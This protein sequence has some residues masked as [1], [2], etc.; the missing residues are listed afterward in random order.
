MADMAAGAHVELV[1][2]PRADDV[3]IGAAR[4]MDAGA[5]ALAI[6]ALLDLL[7]HDALAH[8][9]ALVRALVAPGEVFAVAAKHADLDA[10]GRDDLAAAFGD[11]VLGGYEQ[12]AHCNG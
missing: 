2:V 11:L 7:H 5:L 6:K 9:P 3:L 10:A 8:R 4:V 1:A 12:L